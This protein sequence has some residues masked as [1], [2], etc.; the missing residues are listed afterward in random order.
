L[1]GLE[2]AMNTLRRVQGAGDV[3]RLLEVEEKIIEEELPLGADGDGA[4][5]EFLGLLGS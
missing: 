3:A 5:F 4:S 2:D 1:V